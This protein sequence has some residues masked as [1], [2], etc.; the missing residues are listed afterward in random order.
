MLVPFYQKEDHV[1]KDLV[2]PTSENFKLVGE[3]LK[4]QKYLTTQC[5]FIAMMEQDC[6][7]LVLVQKH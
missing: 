7:Y 3:I 1:Q 6:N 2:M 4:T 5:A